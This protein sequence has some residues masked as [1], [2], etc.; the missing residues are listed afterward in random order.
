MANA[1]EVSAL[2]CIK[3]Y[4]LGE[5]S[6]LPYPIS[7]PWSFNFDFQFQINQPKN[8]SSISLDH[9]FT[10]LLQT[11]TEIPTFEFDFKPQ[12]TQPESP[13]TLTY[14]PQN[15]QLK[16]KPLLEIALPNKT[17]WIQFRKPDLKSEVVV[18]KSEVA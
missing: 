7:Q 6:P 5:F 15:P 14:H 2:K 16:R 13:K 4:L 18:Q 11:D 10:N 12:T 3:L 1:D 9:Y 8:D 17:E